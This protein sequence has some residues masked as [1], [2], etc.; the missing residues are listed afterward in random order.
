MTHSNDQSIQVIDVSEMS[1]KELCATLGIKYV[2][3]YK[4]AIFWM[5]ASVGV[6]H[7]IYAVDLLINIGVIK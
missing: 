1:Q 2:P 7:I 5:F 4:S 6:T 3:W